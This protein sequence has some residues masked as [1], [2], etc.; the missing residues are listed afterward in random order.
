LSNDVE[1]EAHG[2]FEFKH[3]AVQAEVVF[4]TFHV[5]PDFTFEAVRISV[6]DFENGSKW[7]FGL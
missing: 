7:R 6:E 4:G 3:F 5:G 1:E 2:A